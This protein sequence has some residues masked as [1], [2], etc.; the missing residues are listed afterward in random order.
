LENNQPDSGSG[1]LAALPQGAGGGVSQGGGIPAG[2]LVVV[3]DGKPVATMSPSTGEVRPLDGAGGQAV[4][5]LPD[6]GAV[7][8]AFFSIP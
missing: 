5:R 6:S 4:A 1:L 7:N 2:Q 8:D 3:M